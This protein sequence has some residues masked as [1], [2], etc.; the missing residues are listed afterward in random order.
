MVT[1][2]KNKTKNPFGVMKGIEMEE[3]WLRSKVKLDKVFFKTL[4]QVLV[5]KGRRYQS[6]YRIEKRK[7]K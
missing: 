2:N 7:R 5:I 3:E 4:G 6:G 1:E